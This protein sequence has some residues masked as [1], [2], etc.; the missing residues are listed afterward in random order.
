MTL[1]ETC[2]TTRSVLPES[3]RRRSEADR[4][5]PTGKDGRL[6]GIRKMLKCGT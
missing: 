4:I 1:K 2:E 5:A 3:E 6:R